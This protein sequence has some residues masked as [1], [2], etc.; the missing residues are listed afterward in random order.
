MVSAAVRAVVLGG[1]KR[2]FRISD[3]F[4]SGTYAGFDFTDLDVT[5]TWGAGALKLLYK[6]QANTPVASSGDVVQLALD[7]SQGIVIGSEQTTNGDFSGGTTSW[8]QQAA[9]FGVSGGVATLT[10][11][12]ARADNT[13]FATIP[14]ALYR[15]SVTFISADHAAFVNARRSDTTASIGSVGTIFGLVGVFYFVA[16][17][18]STFMSIGNGGGFGG[19]WTSVIDAVSCKS[20]SGN[21]AWQTTSGSRPTWQANSGNPYINFD[22]VDDGLLT[23]LLPVAASMTIAACFRAGG[24]GQNIIGA[25]DASVN[26]SYL[27]IGNAGGASNC[28]GAGWGSQNQNTIFGGTSIVGTDVVGL[29]RANA[30]T[31]EL[32]LNGT[33][34]YGPKP[35]AGTPNTTIP[36]SLGCRNYNGTLDSFL[37]GKIYRAVAVQRFITDSM[38]VPLMQTLGRGVV[39]F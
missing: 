4:A 39:S 3:L 14:G 25:V 31:V 17:T 2:P 6:D 7:K 24:P 37:T 35:P 5:K 1:G 26:R 29:F 28:F 18:A 16:A 36:L 11:D 13:A 22:G 23:P 9:T 15:V 34:V 38:I 19:A 21:H 30:S 10:G 33:R 27:G 8:T 32:W 20:V 12:N